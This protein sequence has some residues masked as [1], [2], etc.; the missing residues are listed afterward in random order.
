MP[1]DL[2]DQKRRGSTMELISP[3]PMDVCRTVESWQQLGRRVVTGHS[4]LYD[5]AAIRR[6][7]AAARLHLDRWLLAQ[8]ARLFLRRRPRRPC[9]LFLSVGSDGRRSFV[10][11]TVSERSG[12]FAAAWLADIPGWFE[13]GDESLPANASLWAFWDGQALARVHDFL[14]GEPSGLMAVD[15]GGLG[16]IS[17]FTDLDED[18][19]EQIVRDPVERWDYCPIPRSFAEQVQLEPGKGVPVRHLAFRSMG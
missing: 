12:R 7:A 16:G 19:Y 6:E 15:I 8:V 17:V 2:V 1:S 13:S 4:H 5:L 11:L 3:S 18:E 10:R 9:A 14:D